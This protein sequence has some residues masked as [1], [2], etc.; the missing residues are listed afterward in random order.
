MSKWS[1]MRSLTNGF[2][3]GKLPAKAFEFDRG[4]AIV[5]E[6]KFI[7]CKNGISATAVKKIKNDLEKISMLM[8]MHNRPNEDNNIFGIMVIFNKTNKYD[9]SFELL[10]PKYGTNTNINTNKYENLTIIYGT[11]NVT[12]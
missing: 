1:T 11:G 9:Q 8:K 5:I 7:K 6:I 10:L 2:G 3:F 12:F 4:K